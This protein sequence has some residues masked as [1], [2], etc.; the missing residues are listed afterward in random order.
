MSIVTFWNATKEQCGST[1]SSIAF[2]TQLAIDHNIKVL[3][4]ST[5][6]ND[7]IVKQCFWREKKNNLPGVFGTNTRMNAIEKNGIEGLDR[8]IRSGKISPEII[9]DY[10][11]TILTGRLEVLLGIEGAGAQYDLIKERYSQIINIADKY[12]DM[13][14]VDL[15]KRL[16]IHQE[17]ILKMSNVVVSVIPQR[18]SEI[19]RV[20]ELLK[21]GTIL[22][23]QS[24]IFL[25]GKYEEKT[26]FNAKNL[27]RSIL[28][29]K[30][31]VNTI[32]YNILFFE[33]SQEGKIIDVFLNFMRI[34][35]KDKNYNFVTE[36]KRLI[37]EVQNRMQELR[38]V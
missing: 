26:K 6:L 27:T 33:A 38:M 29:Q 8:V 30:K 21:K 34:K 4:I 2:A 36:I 7:P 28:K 18:I 23:K 3:L 24:T 22:K 5:S 20:Q 14:I 17:E 13:V 37:D 11:K 32:P 12:Y 10:T 16:G 31:L 9:T 15:D 25:I 35:E 1:S 19:K